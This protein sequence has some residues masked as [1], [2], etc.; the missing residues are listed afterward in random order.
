MKLIIAGGRNY[1]LTKEDFFQLDHLHA[2]CP[3]TEVACGLALGAD[4]C[5]KVWAIM[6]G[7]PVKDFPAEWNI[8]GKGAG[9]L[10]NAD[11]AKYAE[12][13]AI[14]PGGKGSENM[15]ELATQRKLLIFDYRKK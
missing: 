13:L 2:A 4:V 8:H 1:W 12:A 3:V 10:R 5:G 11:M 14:F 7:I 6:H 9:Y 15:L